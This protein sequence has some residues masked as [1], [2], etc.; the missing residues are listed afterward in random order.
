MAEV[1]RKKIG[2]DDYITQTLISFFV[3]CLDHCVASFG[4]PKVVV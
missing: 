4:S 3:S 1:G 2:I